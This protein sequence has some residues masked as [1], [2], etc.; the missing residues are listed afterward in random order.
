MEL[1]NIFRQRYLLRRSILVAVYHLEVGIK[2]GSYFPSTGTE[3]SRCLS[4]P[5]DM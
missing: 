2:T 4:V 5:N 3:H 1:P